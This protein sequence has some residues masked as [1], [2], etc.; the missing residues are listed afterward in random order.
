MIRIGRFFQSINMNLLNK[1][2]AWLPIIFLVV[3]GGFVY[4]FNLNNELFWDDDDWIINNVYV[5][6]INWESIKFWFSN[7]A[8]AGIGLQSNYYRPFLFFT[9]ALNWVVSETKPFLWHLVSNSI[10]IAN[11]VLVFVLLR[12][13]AG[14]IVAFLT[15]LFFAIHPLNTEAVAYISGRGDPLSVFFILLALYLWIIDLRSRLSTGFRWLKTLSLAAFVLAILSRETGV[16]FP[17]LLMVFYIAFSDKNKL[18]TAPE[19]GRA[20]DGRG[21]SGVKV[22]DVKNAFKEALPYFG[23]VAVYGILRLTV[24]NFQNTLNFYSKAN[25]YSENIIYRLFTFMHVLIDYFRLLFVPT[26]LHMERSMVV[27]TSLFQWPVWLGATIIAILLYCLI[28]M[29]K[30]E[31]FNNVTIQQSEG[32]TI[33]QFNNVTIFPF[34]I[35]LFGTGWFFIGLAMVSGITPINALIYEHWLYLPMVGFWLIASFYLIKLFD[36]LKSKNLIFR[37]LLLTGLLAYLLFF[38]YQ[39]VQRNVLWGNPVEFY[40]DILKYE[41]D[42]IK[43]NNNLG[44]RYF[45]QGDMDRAEFYYRKAVGSG[46]DF[47]QPHFNIGSILQSRGDIEGAIAEF[48]KAIEIDPGF[49]YPYQNL[50]VIY[51]QRGD[52]IQTVINIEKLKL[53]LPGNPRVYYNSALVYVA[54]NNK[55]KALIDLNE[56]LK[57][58]SVDP[59]TGKLIA[60]LIRQLT[61]K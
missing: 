26:G 39:S 5:H 25:P 52:F 40:K 53:L 36:F 42:S 51:A 49:F 13:Y 11:A 34:R 54:L 16:I 35:W 45:N 60:E 57:Y 59:E 12:R 24:L 50:A 29:Y 8:L 7:N 41:P 21:T 17:F 31:R 30:K 38:G 48:N 15:A 18:T 32:A 33:R 61:I 46:N 44:N 28:V 9:F 37:G 14:Q 20:L 4:S 19:D 47:A 43:I 6:S 10:H 55:E 56:G 23:V 1:K 22:F 3:I 58:S 2:E 27:H